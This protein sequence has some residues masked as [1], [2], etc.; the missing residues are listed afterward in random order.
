MAKYVIDIPDTDDYKIYSPLNGLELGLPWKIMDKTYTLPTHIKLKPYIESNRKAIEDE[1]WKIA[2]NIHGM[3]IEDKMSCFGFSLTSAVTSNFSY[4]E[5]KT[6]LEAWKKQ[7]DEINIGDEVTYTLCGDTAT[8][9]V[10]G[11]KKNKYYGFNPNA[12]DYNDVGEYCDADMLK[13]TGRHFPE[14][15]E[16]LE[17]MRGES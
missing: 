4:Q 3:S 9:I 8:L 16:L 15:A 2:D 7:N 17:K 5:I 11:K 6:K 14:V 13:K 1:V 12:P 10:L